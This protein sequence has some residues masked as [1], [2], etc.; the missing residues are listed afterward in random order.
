MF[1]TDSQSG[2]AILGGG[3][4][5]M[6]ALPPPEL[7]VTKAGS[8]DVTPGVLGTFQCTGNTGQVGEEVTNLVTILYHQALTL[9]THTGLVLSNSSASD[10]IIC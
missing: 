5:S 1:S 9:K 3:V 6:G 8:Q 10:F 4:Q 2:D 7:F